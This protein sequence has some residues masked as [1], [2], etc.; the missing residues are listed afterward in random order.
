M[1]L[2]KVDYGYRPSRLVC[3][4]G[5]RRPEG[6]FQSD[7]TGTA[8]GVYDRTSAIVTCSGCGRVIT[9]DGAVIGRR[10]EAIA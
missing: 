9:A 8:T 5:M 6:F 1:E 2:A 4:C 10:E 7:A 3:P